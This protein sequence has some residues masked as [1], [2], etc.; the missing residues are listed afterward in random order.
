MY[1]PESFEGN[2]NRPI[3]L[4]HELRGY[5]RGIA[6][7]RS[8]ATFAIPRRQ[9]AANLRR[10]PINSIGYEIVRRMLKPVFEEHAA[11]IDTVQI[12]VCDKPA[13]SFPL[14]PVAFIR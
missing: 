6:A 4:G 3:N 5:E 10:N 14:L 2:L 13:L 1:Q 9:A 8:L 7:I 12:Y 11:I